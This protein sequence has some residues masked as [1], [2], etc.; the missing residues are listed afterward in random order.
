M[1]WR[2]WWG[3]VLPVWDTEPPA[4]DTWRWRIASPHTNTPAARK[5]RQQFADFPGHWPPAPALKGFVARAIRGFGAR[6][7]SMAAPRTYLQKT[8]GC[9]P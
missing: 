7:T 9:E 3:Q 4:T 5:H 1:E 2:G 8:V 6:Q